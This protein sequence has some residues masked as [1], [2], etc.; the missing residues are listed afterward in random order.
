MSQPIKPGTSA[1]AKGATGARKSGA[2]KNPSKTE[3]IS[4]FPGATS[5]AVLEGAPLIE[6]LT[7]EGGM[8]PL[9]IFVRD[10]QR[11]LQP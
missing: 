1:R 9:G 5:P 3:R 8:R 4:A 10:A 11:R 6:G 2:A 7:M